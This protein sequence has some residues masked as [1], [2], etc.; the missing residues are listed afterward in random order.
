[1]ALQRLKEAA[2]KAKKEVSSSLQTDINLPYL[3]ADASGPKHLNMT[4]SRAKFNEM[5]RDLVEKT[6]ISCEKALQECRLF[7]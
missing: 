6:R 7:Y 4:L 3:T 1:M 2:E 5:T